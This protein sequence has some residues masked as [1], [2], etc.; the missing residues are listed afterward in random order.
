MFANDSDNNWNVTDEMS[1]TYSS[2]TP[3][4]KW[5][6]PYVGNYYRVYSDWIDLETEVD[7][8]W[9]STNETGSWMNYTAREASYVIDDL[10]NDGSWTP[11]APW[12]FFGASPVFIAN[13]TNG[14]IRDG[15]DVV[16]NFANIGMPGACV[17]GT[18]TLFSGNDVVSTPI[19][20]TDYETVVYWVYYE[21]Q[22]P[23]VPVTSMTI[24]NWGTTSYC[25]YS[26]EVP[27][28]P[29]W[30]RIEL[31]TNPSFWVSVDS[32]PCGGTMTSIDFINIWFA[33]SI[34]YEASCEEYEA[35]FVIDE[36]YL[37]SPPHD[38][39]KTMFTWKN[40]SIIT[41]GN[42]GWKIFANDTDGY[43]NVTSTGVMLQP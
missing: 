6:N 35:Y 34:S 10:P 30:N 33:P 32:P 1:F 14:Y 13:N 31:D 42:V 20:F 4:P 40:D 7:H 39:F 24:G 17:N 29:G 3:N 26:T 43:E 19:D 12:M 11:G 16:I 5:S 21:P 25:K 38:D 27:L 23:Q 2:T 28:A 8:T 36:V 41:P 22:G 9:L 15:L 18:Y 37:R